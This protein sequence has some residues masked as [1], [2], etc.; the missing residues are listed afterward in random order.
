MYY[1]CRHLLDL[2][3]LAN[4]D[5]QGLWSLISELEKVM[6]DVRETNVMILNDTEHEACDKGLGSTDICEVC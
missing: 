1:I 3:S 6:K 5:T 2:V 4:N